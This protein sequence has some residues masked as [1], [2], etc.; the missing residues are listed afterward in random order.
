M[1]A[2]VLRRW[3]QRERSIGVVT[4]N[5][6]QR[7]LIERMLWDSEVPGIREALVLKSDSLFVK[8]LENVQ[9]DERDV[10]IFSTG[11]SV[12]DDGVLPLNFGPL[13]RFGGERRLNVAVTRARRRVMVFSS[14]EPEDIRLADTSSVGLRHLREYLELAKYGVPPRTARTVAAGRHADEI[15]TAL[16]DAGCTVE[17]AVGLSDFTVDLAVAAPGQDQPRLAVL[18]DGSVW[19]GRSTTAIATRCRTRC[20][21]T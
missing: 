21:A 17:T 8:N 12:G 6:Q 15:A 16:R 9:G 5:I 3:E 14:F 4:F 1:V 2:E 18:L 7:G 13:N 19:A 10:V 20:S 11:F